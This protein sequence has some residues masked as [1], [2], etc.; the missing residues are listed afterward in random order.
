MIERSIDFGPPGMRGVAD[1]RGK[2]TD[3]GRCRDR[4]M[5]VWRASLEVGLFVEKKHPMSS[6]GSTR[7]DAIGTSN[8][9]LFWKTGKSL[10][11]LQPPK[12]CTHYASV[13]P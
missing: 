11:S 10:H 1:I 3:S 6:T 13:D 7:L 5:S 2:R 4:N 9:F 12:G 8:D